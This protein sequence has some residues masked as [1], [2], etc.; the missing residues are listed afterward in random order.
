M[1]SSSRSSK[2]NPA[3]AH[4]KDIER[5]AGYD[6]LKSM[7]LKAGVLAMM[8]G[9]ALYPKI[10]AEAEVIE[11]EMKMKEDKKIAFR[12]RN[13]RREEGEGDE[14]RNGRRSERGATRSFGGRGGG[15][16]MRVD[17][18]D[19][20]RGEGFSHRDEKRGR[21]ARLMRRESVDLQRRREERER[22]RRRQEESMMSA[23]GRDRTRE[24]VTGGYE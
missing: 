3:R 23:S 19:M 4:R 13:R 11:R 1:F 12:K 15:Q 16:L 10:A 7:G 9:L 8:A 21:E 6:N 17:E 20:K 22:V 18:Y 5:E 14:R 24:W 2:E